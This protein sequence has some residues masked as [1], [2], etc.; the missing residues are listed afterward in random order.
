VG[1]PGVGAGVGPCVTEIAV[2]VLR[3]GDATWLYI[4]FEQRFGLTLVLAPLAF[5]VKTGSSI[6]LLMSVLL[7]LPD[8]DPPKE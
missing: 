3:V 1:T 5:A 4:L 8:Q 7:P 2:H 6:Q